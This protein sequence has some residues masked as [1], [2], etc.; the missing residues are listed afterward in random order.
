MTTKH[1]PRPAMPRITTFSYPAKIYANFLAIFPTLFA[2]RPTTLRTLRTRPTHRHRTRLAPPHRRL[3]GRHRR[4]S[5][6]VLLEPTAHPRTRLEHRL[7]HPFSAHPQR[8][9]RPVE[10]LGRPRRLRYLA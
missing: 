8:R 2:R 10:I 6:N 3:P 9:G 1:R 7:R 4:R 5:R